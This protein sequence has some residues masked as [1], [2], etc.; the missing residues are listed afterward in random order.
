LLRSSPRPGAAAKALLTD[1]N[2]AFKRFDQDRLLT[3][4]DFVVFDTELTGLS[5]RQD[6]IVAI[7]AVRI[8]GLRIIAG[9]VMHSHIRP[10]N[11]SPTD[12]T[13]IHRITPEQLTTAPSAAEVMT[14]FLR[15]IGP[16][17]L[18]GHYVGMDM[19]FVN[20]AAR[21][22]FGGKIK[23]PCLDTMLLAEVYTQ[24]CWE[25][26]YDRFNL[27]TSYNLNDLSR[28]YNLPLFESHDALQDAFQT[29]YLFLYLVKHFQLLGCRTL[30]DLHRAGK[31]RKTVI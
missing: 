24:A 15:F 6:E 20:R 10:A 9:E 3:D 30:R 25:H 22:V 1:H 29:A 26:Y 31:F 12:G 21:H 13:L 16:S 17:L 19:H 2:G 5:R 18:V 11:I 23:N 28:R 27:R 4:Y 14:S 8:R 7:G